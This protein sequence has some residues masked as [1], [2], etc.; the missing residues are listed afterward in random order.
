MQPI[1]KLVDLPNEVYVP[2]GRVRIPPG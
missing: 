2:A 1:F